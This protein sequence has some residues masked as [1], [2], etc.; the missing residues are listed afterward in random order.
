M[1]LQTI[2]PSRALNR[3]PRWA[4]SNGKWTKAIQPGKTARQLFLKETDF[5]LDN[6][7]NS[8]NARLI[9]LCRSLE[10]K[11]DNRAYM[12]ACSCGNRATCYEI[13][14]NAPIPTFLCSGCGQQAEQAVGYSGTICT[15]YADLS[16][17]FPGTAPK[18]RALRNETLKY[19]REAKGFKKYVTAR[20][21]KRFIP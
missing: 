17:A 11:F 9:G 10:V 14:S 19:V 2:T 20:K 12:I 13:T 16:V 5:Y 7:I 21:A 6:C 8:S 18:D 4:K 1:K 15:R 3:L